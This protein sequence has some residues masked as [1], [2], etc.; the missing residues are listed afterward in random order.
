MITAIALR[1]TSIVKRET[2]LLSKKA[3]GRASLAVTQVY[4]AGLGAL[5]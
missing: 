3:L 4:L 1:L 2:C 5:E